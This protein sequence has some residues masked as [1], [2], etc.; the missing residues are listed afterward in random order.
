MR[1]T[2]RIR[3]SA[4]VAASAALA[5][6]AVAQEATETSSFGERYESEEITEFG[7]GSTIYTVNINADVNGEQVTI[8]GLSRYFESYNQTEVEQ[9]VPGSYSYMYQGVPVTVNGWSA[10]QLTDSWYDLIDVFTEDSYSSEIIGVTTVQTTSGDGPDAL[11]PIGN[12]GFCGNDG[13]SGATNYDAFDGMFAQCEYADDYLA[14]APGTVN[15]NTHTTTVYRDIHYHFESVDDGYTD[16]YLV[17]PTASATASS[18]TMERTVATTTTVR[19]DSRATQLTGVVDGEMLF[20]ETVD[21]TLASA[22][23]Q[24]ALATLARPRGHAVGGAPAV[25]VWSAPVLTGSSEQLTSSSSETESDTESFEVVTVTETAGGAVDIGNLGAC[26]ST[27]TSGTTTG[28]T[29]TGAFAECQGGVSYVLSSGETNT[30]T[31]RLT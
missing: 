3:A 29:P 10:P 26:T 11:V 9:A 7:E 12:R 27:G 6:P 15:T 14:I 22:G 2:A 13:A 4:L 20:D 30:N 21:G 25:V 31:H 23:V 1:S 24:T 8:A 17:T 28:G 16:I 18:G 5:T 19:T